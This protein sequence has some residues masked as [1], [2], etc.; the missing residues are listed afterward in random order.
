[1]LQVFHACKPTTNCPLISHL[2]CVEGPMEGPVEGPMVNHTMFVAN[3]YQAKGSNRV[4]DMVLQAMP[5]HLAAASPLLHQGHMHIIAISL[6]PHF[7]TQYHFIQIMRLSS[8]I[9]THIE[10]VQIY[11]DY[12]TIW[13][14][15]TFI[16]P[17]VVLCTGRGRNSQIH[18]LVAHILALAVCKEKSDSLPHFLHLHCSD[19]SSRC[20]LTPQTNQ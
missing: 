10:R 14:K 12:Q 11:K 18:I 2:M 16:A 3:P 8:S 6:H 7:I 1:M 15:W 13:V 4:L 17:T 20:T 5:I 9:G 19:I